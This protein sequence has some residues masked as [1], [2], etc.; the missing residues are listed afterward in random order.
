MNKL[1]NKCYYYSCHHSQ[2]W[3]QEAETSQ[4]Q[5]DLNDVSIKTKYNERQGNITKGFELHIDASEFLILSHR[6]DIRTFTFKVLKCV[7]AALQE[8]LAAGP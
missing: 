3:N 5:R 4:T 1:Q 6:L 8:G 7:H 2:S